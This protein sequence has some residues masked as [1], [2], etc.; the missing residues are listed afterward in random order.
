[1]NNQAHLC[2]VINLC[3]P[4]IPR[5]WVAVYCGVPKSTTVPA[6]PIL[7]T[8]QVF[9]YPCGTLVMVV[10]VVVVTW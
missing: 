10:V 3:I 5:V 1:M 4:A 2:R 8:P 7:E 9:P 6:L